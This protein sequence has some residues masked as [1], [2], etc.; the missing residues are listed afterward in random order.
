MLPCVCSVIDH[1]WRQNVVSRSRVCHWCSYHILTSSVIYYWIELRKLQ[2]FK[3][4]LK[5]SSPFLSSEQPC[6][7][8]SLDVALNIAWVEKIRF[9]NLRLR[10]RVEVIQ[11][12][13]WMKGALATVEICVL[14]GWRFLNHFDIVS[15]TH[16]SCD[17]V[18][19][20]LWLA[21][22]SSLLCPETD[23]NIRIGK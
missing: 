15:E 17:T 5:K 6:E 21:I 18:D 1:R 7:P 11:F 23:R 3:K 22:L 9:E 12:E 19:R 2:I 8:K 13:V 14:C 10:S 20:G 4:M 16:F